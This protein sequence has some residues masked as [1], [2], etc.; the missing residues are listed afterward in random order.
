MGTRTA[1]R[2]ASPAGRP[3]AWRWLGHWS[4]SH[5][6]SSWM[7]P[8]PP[9]T[10]TTR[11]ELRR[12][13]AEHLSAF[14]GPRLLITHDPTDAFLLADEIHILEDG[15]VTQSGT[16]DEIRRRPRTPYVADL[17]GSNLV[18]GTAGAGVIDTG[19]HRLRVA[20][21]EIAGPVLAVIRASAIAVHLSQPQGSPRNAWPTR[22][23][24]IEH[25]GDRAR[26]LIGHPLPLTAEVTD[27]AAREMAMT[28]G[29]EIWVSIKAT[30]IE[31]QPYRAPAVE[32]A[33]VS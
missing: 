24:R 17:T 13:L 11:I 25:L 8:W 7:S 5:A 18:T 27:D 31:V 20:D 23:E 3:S 15:S 1:S 32:G 2:A 28:E 12:T 14:E 6:F 19:S 30:E 4:P 9:S 29:V 33:A 21:H 26:V 10:C 22:I 16:V